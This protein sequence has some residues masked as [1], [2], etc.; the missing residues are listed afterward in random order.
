MSLHDVQ[1]PIEY[2][3][4]GALQRSSSFLAVFVVVFVLLAVCVLMLLRPG[5]MVPEEMLCA[6]ML[7]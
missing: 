6:N 1:K 2:C 7:A 5:S 3:S 4:P